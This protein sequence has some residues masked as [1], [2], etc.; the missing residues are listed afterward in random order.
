M[1]QD[2]VSFQEETC[3]FGTMA[4]RE[5][6]VMMRSTRT[7]RKYWYRPNDSAWMERRYKKRKRKQVSLWDRWNASA[8]AHLWK[9]GK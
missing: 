6:E 2:V 9:V 5:I 4:R 8:S 7:V 3:Q 1:V